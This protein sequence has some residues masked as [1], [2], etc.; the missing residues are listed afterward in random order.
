MVIGPDGENYTEVKIKKLQINGKEQVG[1]VVP[2]DATKNQRS[3]KID[4]FTEGI[5]KDDS[6]TDTPVTPSE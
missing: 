3:I 6:N 5:K 4:I 2:A 1:N